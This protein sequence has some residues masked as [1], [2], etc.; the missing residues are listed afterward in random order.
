MAQLNLDY[1]SGKDL[2]SDGDIENEILEIVKEGKWSENAADVKF[3]VLY[4]LTAVR[5]NILNWYPFK[6]DG[7]CLEI[8][9]GC[10][11]ITGLLCKRLAKVVSVELSKRR[12]EINFARHSHLENL[13][14]RVG[15][16]N[17]MDFSE[18]FVSASASLLGSGK[19][20][21]SSL[22]AKCIIFRPARILVST[23]SG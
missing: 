9:S 3:P 21:F 19:K 4:H 1:Y 11:A 23:Y 17:D 14:I 6:K 18:G 16:Q 5:E 20:P 7:S 12:A 8:G 15:N 10:G 2:Y 22:D 13:E